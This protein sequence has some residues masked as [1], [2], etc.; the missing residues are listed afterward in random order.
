METALGRRLTLIVAPAGF[1]K[2]TLLAEWHEILHSRGHRVAWLSLDADDND[3]QQFG[4]YLVA[5]FDAK[6]KPGMAAAILRE[7]PLTPMK[8][9]HAVLLNEIAECGR[10]V[11]LFV[12]EFELLNSR[13]S[14]ALISRLLRY[15]PPNLHLIFGSRREPNLPLGGLTTEE[16]ILVL[17]AAALRFT[18]DDAQNF[19]AQADG[20]KLDRSSVEMLNGAAEGWATGLQLAALALRERADAAKLA[21]DLA[22]NR[23]GIDSYLDGTVLSQLPREVFQFA[24]RVSILDRMNAGACD[25]IMGAGAR[26]WE[27]LD[28]LERHNVFTR[29]LDADRQ[30]FRF[31]AL[32]AD[33]LRR[34]A[35]HQLN[36]ALPA[37][38]RRASRWFASQDL[39][40][41]AVRHALAGGEMMQAAE[42]A[43]NCASTM[44]DRSDVPT[45]LRWFSKLPADLVDRS[46]RLT[47]A[48]A[49]AQTLAFQLR[50]AHSSIEALA[51]GLAASE[52]RP[53]SPSTSPPD[54]ALRAEVTAARA[55]IAA[56]VDDAPLSLRLGQQAETSLDVPPW[57]ARFANAAKIFGL[58]YAGRF[59]EIRHIRETPP[60]A[61]MTEPLYASV[62]RFSMLGLASLVEGRLQEAIATFEFALS[63]AETAVGRESAAAALP[64]GYLATL[65]YEVDD[66]PRAQQ[67]LHSRIAVAMQAC[68]LGSLL[69]YCLG[70]ARTYARN[71]D[72]GSALVVLAEAREVASERQWLRMRVGCDAEAVRLHL[73]GGRVAEAERLANDL[74]ALIPQTHPSP[75]GSFLETWANWCEIRARIAL[76]KGRP[77]EA[78]ELYRDLRP[79][80]STVGMR[81]L[82][83]R[84]SMLMAIACECVGD[85]EAAR[86]ALKVAL[87]YAATEP[88]I[89]SF[90]DEGEPM[91]RTLKTYR[92]DVDQNESLE[93]RQIERLIAA[94][95]SKAEPVIG[96]AP[97][98]AAAAA[99]S[100]REMEILNHISRG[101]SNKEIARALRIAPET[102]KWHLKNIYE[103]LNVN[104]RIEA[105]Q[106]GLGVAR[107]KR[108]GR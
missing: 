18:A 49:W 44:I 13:D 41:E 81:F 99:L 10:E 84:I 53:N 39:W 70:A 15:A 2:T 103:K 16:Q 5:A 21:R 8:V 23:F 59:D 93:E 92:R 75:M 97:R 65:Y 104:S 52:R 42:W 17:D 25:A 32:M 31:H 4:I 38:H 60:L 20:V 1:G 34:R 35:Q 71:G 64:A 72:V 98:S 12:D 106:N 50:D 9:V 40:P 43:E 80:L 58:A 94:F 107:S 76:A 46:M 33:A 24:L 69:R 36:E 88:M 90:V 37:L 83:A 3:P 95:A 48:K 57:V 54:D 22:S 62:Y 28:W 30:W 29:A 55:A 77:H 82:E 67:V 27:K 100:A 91:L 14:I 47:L 102:I 6:G 74:D 19:F 86:E 68:S 89:N 79:R 85:K 61:E 63:R 56:L 105:V 51:N 26:S 87:R 45:L 73:L 78:A 66:L 7:D 11:F 101:L 108:S 96:V